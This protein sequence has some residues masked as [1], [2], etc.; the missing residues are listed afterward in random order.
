MELREAVRPITDDARHEAALREIEA[1]WDAPVG[2]SEHER[3]DVL[4]T[5][6]EAY[7]ARRWPRAAELD[8][9]DFLREHM[10]A[11]GYGEDHLAQVVGPEPLASDILARRRPL[12]LEHIRAVSRSWGL[13][14]DLLIREYALA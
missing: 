2:S 1:L 6:V 11:N 3:M 10:A 9:V 7:E 14:S 4:A 8:P 5:L 13:P 12:S